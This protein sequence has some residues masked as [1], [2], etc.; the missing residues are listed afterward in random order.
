MESLLA[1]LV[2]T[3][4]ILIVVVLLIPDRLEQRAWRNQQQRTRIAADLDMVAA[5]IADLRQSIA[6]YE[7]LTSAAYRSQVAP[8]CAQ[9]DRLQSEQQAMARQIAALRLPHIPRLPLPIQH[10][11]RTPGD[12]SAVFND[13]T[14]LN[15]MDRAVRSADASV[16]TARSASDD[17]NALPATL[18]TDGQAL[19]R[20]LEA[21]VAALRVE[22]RSGIEALDELSHALAGQQALVEELEARFHSGT[23]LPQLDAAAHQLEAATAA[24]ADL[25]ARVDELNRARLQLDR[26]IQETAAE[27]D[28]VQVSA[29][30]GAAPTPAARPTRAM[31]LQA[32][33]MLNEIAP[34]ARRVHDFTRA[35]EAVTAAHQLIGF[36]R[37]LSESERQLIYLEAHDAGLGFG[38]D[39]AVARRELAGLML[40]LSPA[41][42]S[43]EA[44]HALAISP[45]LAELSRRS[46]DLH[47]ELSNLVQRQREA[48]VQLERD[49]VADRDRLVA[50]W[51]DGQRLLTLTNEDPLVGRYQRILAQFTAARGDPAALQAARQD[52]AAF[53]A[54]QREWSERLATQQR[55]LAE[56]GAELPRLVDRAI[57][58][59]KGWTCLQQAVGAIQQHVADFAQLQSRFRKAHT[60]AEA[61]AVMDQFE[62]LESDIR[63]EYDLLADQA[64]R[65][66]WLEDD[67]AKTLALVAVNVDEAAAPRRD[68]TQQMI[69]HRVAQAH[70]ATR[71]EDANQA[72]LWAA[73][74]AQNLTT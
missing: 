28:D 72:M 27:L 50:A 7:A 2:I 60:T 44:M 48:V 6:P 70:A 11:L 57:T 31:L 26:R 41:A 39:I 51:E 15:Q 40:R 55:W 42:A 68:R 20:R 69:D 12:A 34:E 30:G 46:A 16:K 21:I 43:P 53:L 61:L 9:L 49:A 22:Q 24:T 74:L 17:L 32:A 62:R 10:F 71:C 56:Y 3:V 8:I 66:R 13:A 63:R 67:L 5:A 19:L 47:H 37:N 23:P 65:L 33:V 58:E 18:R 38:P 54:S 4:A 14:R 1:I 36:S 52:A 29:K 35:D 59:A 64:T 25:G 45:D 73:E